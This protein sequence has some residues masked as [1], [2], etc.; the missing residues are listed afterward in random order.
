MDVCLDC[1]FFLSEKNY[2]K[3]YF[4]GGGMKRVLFIKRDFLFLYCLVKNFLCKSWSKYVY[5]NI[6]W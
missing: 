6:V 5:K 3:N 4:W 2:Y 1:L